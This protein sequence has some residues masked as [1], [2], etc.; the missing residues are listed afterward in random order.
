LSESFANLIAGGDADA[1][2]N[3]M[4]L[5]R[6]RYLIVANGG[7]HPFIAIDARP[8]PPDLK[9]YA[10]T[11]ATGTIEFNNRPDVMNA[12]DI[13]YVKC[14]AAHEMTHNDRIK[15]MEDT[16]V[17]KAMLKY[18][19]KHQTF[20]DNLRSLELQINTMFESIRLGLE[21]D[22]LLLNDKKLNI[23]NKKVDVQARQKV[24]T[25]SKKMIN[26]N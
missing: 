10:W 5:V 13:T 7:I 16:A 4:R 11:T 3:Y 26:D 17:E 8:G 15:V 19:D 25:S 9:M 22:S 18:D 24:T 12:D 23:E 20:D 6:R 2:E 14:T 21:Q 1:A